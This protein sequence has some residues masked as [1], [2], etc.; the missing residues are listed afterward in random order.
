MLQ[1]N[2]YLFFDL[3]PTEADKNGNRIRIVGWADLDD[4]DGL[5]DR[6]IVPGNLINE[7]NGKQYDDFRIFIHSP[8]KDAIDGTD[9]NETSIVM[10]IRFDWNEKKDAAKLILGGDAEWRTWENIVSISDDSTL[11]WDLFEAPHHCSWTFFADDRENDEPNKASLDF[12]AKG[13]KNAIVVSS[14]KYISHIDSNPPC[15]KAKNRYL[16]VIEEKNF[17]CTGGNK[18]DDAPTP[19]SFEVTKS[20]FKKI[21]CKINDDEARSFAAAFNEGNLKYGVTGLGLTTGYTIAKS[22]GFYG[23]E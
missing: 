21:Y 10:Q 1:D 16:K 11:E 14:S 2:F 23:K 22:G 3:H 15:K 5:E 20:G 18:Q 17:Y 13:R 6:V 12:L 8:F 19:I 9:R 7:V 4:L